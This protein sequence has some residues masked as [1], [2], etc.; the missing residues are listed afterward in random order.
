MVINALLCN[1]SMTWRSRGI[2]ALLG[3]KLLNAIR[4]EFDLYDYYL[5]TAN[6]SSKKYSTINKRINGKQQRVYPEL[7]KTKEYDEF[8]NEMLRVEKENKRNKE[9]DAIM[10]KHRL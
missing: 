2:L 10:K 9:F 1:S 5:T 4:D 7:I 3:K 8:M 6:G